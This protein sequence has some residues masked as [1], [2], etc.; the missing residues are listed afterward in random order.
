MNTSQMSRV[1]MLTVLS[2]LGASSALAQNCTLPGGNYAVALSVN[3]TCG[4][5]VAET[6][7][8]KFINRLGSTELSALNASYTLNSAA[9]ASGRFNGIEMVMTFSANSPAV[10][11]QVP[12]LGYDKSF[13]ASSRDASIDLLEQDLQKGDILGQI[14][15]A[16][17]Q[18][19]PS[20]PIT[21]VGG[22]IPNVVTSEF[23]QNFTEV[24]TNVAAPPAQAQ[25]A[26][27][28][29]A[30][31][32]GRA[33]NLIGAALQY[34]SFNSTDATGFKNKVEVITLPLS[35][36]FRNN[37]DPRRQLGLSIPITQVDVNGAKVY[38][39]GL[40]MSYRFPVNDQWTLVPSGRIS[41]VGSID[42]ATVSGVYTVGLTSVYIWDLGNFSVSMGN[43]V[44]YNSTLRLQAG[45]YAFDPKINNT[46]LRNGLLLSQPVT[47]GGRRLSVEYSVVDNRYVAGVKPFVK[48]FQELG[49]TIGTNKNAFS[50]RSFLRGGVTYTHGKGTNGVSANIGYWF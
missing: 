17:A 9:I 50:A 23:N 7:A 31:G 34:G 28:T 29:A 46:S 15:K 41:G 42:L 24:A 20:S 6:T 21:G 30:Q 35:Y 39:A 49:L 4:V 10:R 8:E 40:G 19:S 22:L 32:A 13:T 43:M 47:W 2:A 45:D 1:F 12:S 25:A 44:S 38:S 3:N 16:Q 11:F 26:A 14:M 36:T 37:I 48:E 33:S 18:S 5:A 27:Q